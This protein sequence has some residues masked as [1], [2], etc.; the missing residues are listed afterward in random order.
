MYAWFDISIS[1]FPS[2]YDVR[3]IAV[4]NDDNKYI[5]LTSRGNGQSIIVGYNLNTG[6]NANVANAS[7]PTTFKV[8]TAIAENN[9]CHTIYGY[10][11]ASNNDILYYSTEVNIYKISVQRQNITTS[12]VT[13]IVGGGSTVLSTATITGLQLGT[14]FSLTGNQPISLGFSVSLNRLFFSDNTTD[15][16]TANFKIYALNP[17]NNT[18]GR[19]TNIS[20]PTLGYC[21]YDFLLN[22][23]KGIIYV[24]STDALNG[25]STATPYRYSSIATEPA[26]FLLPGTITTTTR[27]PPIT[28]NMIRWTLN[29]PI[30][31]SLAFGP[32]A[33]QIPIASLFSTTDGTIYGSNNSVVSAAIPASTYRI[34]H[35]APNPISDADNTFFGVAN[36]LVQEGGV[37]TNLQGGYRSYSTHVKKK[38]S[39]REIAV[40]ALTILPKQKKTKK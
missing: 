13:R 10:K 31:L 27:T 22:D 25:T 12:T 18:I 15:P 35:V 28:Y 36:P 9:R 30:N 24:T 26:G 37:L 7:S 5:Y 3:S 11:D 4:V 1:L 40:P 39:K 2:A 33:N 16:S 29:N 20:L 38:K 21:I 32:G 34:N 14:S 8:S 23:S 19:I 17:A 6:I